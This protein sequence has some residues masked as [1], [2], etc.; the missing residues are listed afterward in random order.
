VKGATLN[1]PNV[2]SPLPQYNDLDIR[3][4]GLLCLGIEL[5]GGLISRGTGLAAITQLFAGIPSLQPQDI[6]MMDLISV[7]EVQVRHCQG[8]A[9]EGGVWDSPCEQRH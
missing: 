1:S 3:V 6:A 7:P 9:G 8:S 4:T 2:A 5:A